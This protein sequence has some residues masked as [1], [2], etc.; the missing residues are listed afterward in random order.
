[1]DGTDPYII[2]VLDPR[3]TWERYRTAY[4]NDTFQI[5]RR[6]IGPDALIMPRPVDSDLDYSPRDIVFIGWV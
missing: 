3:V 6:L 4:Y 1:A 5:L 2:E